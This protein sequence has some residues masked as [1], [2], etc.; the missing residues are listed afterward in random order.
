LSIQI[1]AK[2]LDRAKQ[3]FI[4]SVRVKNELINNNGLDILVNMAETI[5]LSIKH[6][7]KLLLCGN[8]GSAADA[9]HL[10]GELLV[11]LRSRVNRRS[12][13][14]IALTIDPV[15]MTATGNDYSFEDIFARPLAGLGV[16]GDVL[17][18]IT[19]SGKSPNVIKA[20]K[21]ARDLGIKTLG[22][23]G[24]GGGEA[25]QFCDQAF[26]VP[27]SITGRVQESHITA[28]HV[29]LELLEE[30]LIADGYMQ[31]EN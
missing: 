27:S 9:Q 2:L 19:T 28:G 17:L 20:L 1:D 24:A 21:L 12:L 16:A 31:Q 15:T 3:A 13:P 25:T 6:G 23:L 30:M 18:G 8:G 29:M 11:R 26:I 5:S 10:A 22:F 4:E 7:G 14:A